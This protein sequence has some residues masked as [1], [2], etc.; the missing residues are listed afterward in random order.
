MRVAKVAAGI[1]LVALAGCATAQPKA[2]EPVPVPVPSPTTPLPLLLQNLSSSD[3]STRAAAAWELAGL[4]N[5]PTEVFAGLDRLLADP[6][7]PVRYAGAWALGCLRP[8]APGEIDETP[9]KPKHIT[10]PQY[11]RA[12]FD[13]RL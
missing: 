4:K 12:A 6:Q 9:P 11:P 3:A 5:P 7:R 1:A 10:R 8:R 13:A 2:T